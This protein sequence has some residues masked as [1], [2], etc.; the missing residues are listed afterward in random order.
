MNLAE[1][2]ALALAA[3]ERGWVE[4]KNA[5]EADLVLLNTC[6]VRKTAE[7]RV[8]GRLAH[9]TAL[10]KKH[11]QPGPSF[12]LLIAGC[13]AERLGEDFKAEIPAID[14][15]MGTSA[16]SRFPLILEAMEQG[17]TGNLQ[18]FATTRIF[19]LFKWKLVCAYGKNRAI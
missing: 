5:D 10:K 7:Q 8:M 17:Q 18:A 12:T 13:M 16:R 2:A 4:A 9:Y 15:V 1:S 14:Y 6:S 11:N 3:R 19:P